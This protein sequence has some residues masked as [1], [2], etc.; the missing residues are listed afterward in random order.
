MKKIILIISTLMIVA[1]GG[2]FFFTETTIGQELLSSSKQNVPQDEP[3]V[4]EEN[5]LTT[6]QS[7]QCPGFAIV[8]PSPED[9]VSFPLTII[10]TIHP[11]NNPGPWVVFEGE[12]GSVNVQDTHG[13]IL[14]D[15]VILTL[16]VPWMNT[17]PKPFSVIIPELT[18]APTTADLKLVF[19]DNNVAGPD[20]GQTH[21]CML[22]IVAS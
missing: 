12:A 18:S 19:T 2:Y 1:I 8:S 22:S 14:S 15:N 3:L 10:G 5:I 7:G 20:E 9:T 4:Q 11:I 21:Q 17:D 13:A 16:D 6:L